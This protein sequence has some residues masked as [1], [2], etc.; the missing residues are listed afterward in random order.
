MNPITYT[1][2]ALKPVF[3][4]N[5]DAEELMYRVEY[6]T[7]ITIEMMRGKKKN[8]E[9]VMARHIAMYLIREFTPLNLSMIGRYFNRDHA[10]VI[11]AVKKI[12]Y[13]KEIY[14]DVQDI[15]K[16]LRINGT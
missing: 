9:I 4:I 6:I 7:G 3:P 5:I 14:Q 1:G 11:H 15:L 2:L 10:S 13:E 8:K 12:K 16:R